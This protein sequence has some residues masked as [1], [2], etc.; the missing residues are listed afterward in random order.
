MAK[1]EARSITLKDGRKIFLKTAE[2]SDTESLLDFLDILSEHPEGLSLSPGD[3][4]LTL[5][6]EKKHLIKMRDHSKQLF[7]VALRGTKT[8]GCI[9]F[10]IEPRKRQSHS[11]WFGMSVLPDWRGLGLGDLLLKEMLTWARE[12]P[13][14]KKVKLSVLSDNTKAQAL[15][16][17][18]GFQHT[19]TKYKEITTPDGESYVDE[20]IM[21]LWL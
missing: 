20:H 12:V 8:V 10:N 16:K 14:I 19:G 5:E 6:D 13:E 2:P 18:Y 17:K 3:F 15:Y 9:D 4:S 21:E 1:I 7:L 11:G